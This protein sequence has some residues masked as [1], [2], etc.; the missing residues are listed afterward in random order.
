MRRYCGPM[1]SLALHLELGLVYALSIASAR[2][3][4]GERGCLL[5]MHELRTV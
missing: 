4:F 1:L 5:Q 2:V 3:G